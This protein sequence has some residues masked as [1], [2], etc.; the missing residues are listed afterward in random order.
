MTIAFLISNFVAAIAVLVVLVLLWR[1]RDISGDSTV[2]GQLVNGFEEQQRSLAT[3]QASVRDEFGVNRSESNTLFRGLREEVGGKVTSLLVQTHQGQRDQTES[4]TNAFNGLSSHL[5]E[6]QKGFSAGMEARFSTLQELTE[7]KLQQ[8]RSEQS[9][10]AQTMREETRQA[11]TSFGDSLRRSVL[12]IA[13]F[14]KAES[15]QLRSVVDQRLH[16]LQAENLQKLEQMRQTVDEKLQGTLEARLG[17]SFKQVSD[18][19]EQ[20]HRGLGEMQTLASGVGDLK[21]VLTN[22][23]SR[24]I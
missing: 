19:L 4:L 1:K 10:N 14:Q 9:A 18:R 17:E 2:L 5:L 24:G 16:T 21:K 6:G 15:E 7:N 8:I 22:V 20:V 12:E 3:L 11:L 23:K 13:Q